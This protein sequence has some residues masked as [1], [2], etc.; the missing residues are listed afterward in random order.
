LKNKINI[1]TIIQAR[2][3]SSRL[4]GKVLF[5]LNS[6]PL[7]FRIYE[8]IKAAKYSGTVVVATSYDKSDD[9]IYHL[10]KSYKMEVFR[11]DLTDLLDRHYRAGLCYHADA[12]VKIP[13]DCPL[14]SPSIIDKVI[15]F[16]LKNPQKYDYVSNLHPATYPDGNDVEVVGISALENAWRYAR[17]NYEREHTTPYLWE[18]HHKFRMG[19]VTW[20]NGNDFS[21]SHRWTID[22]QEDYDFIKNV[23]SELAPL[24]PIFEFKD[25]LD[26]LDRKP[27]LS[28][29][30]KKYNGINWYRHHLDDLTTISSEQ[31]RDFEDEKI[32]KRA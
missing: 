23:Y 25:I 13:S 16:Y 28:D 32:N 2:M 1:V 12:I 24:S 6:E 8:R 29:I 4:P 22:Y 27:E 5:P 9:H 20:E 10:C 19:N 15:G 14:I 26:L 7:L 11:G 17:K 18:N 3:S 30:N 21:M 31:T